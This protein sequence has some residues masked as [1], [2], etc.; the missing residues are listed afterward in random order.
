MGYFGFRCAPLGPVP[1]SAERATFFNFHRSRVE[2]AIPDAWSFAS[3]EELSRTARRSVPRGARPGAGCA[4]L[5]RSPVADAPR[6]GQPC[7]L[8][9]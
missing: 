3:V 8:E 2:R 7:P 6:D 1:A 4:A 9:V 5:E